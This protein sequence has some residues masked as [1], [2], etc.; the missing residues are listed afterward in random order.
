[1]TT[2]LKEKKKI[3]DF[4]YNLSETIKEE[5]WVSY[6]DV[7]SDS[8]SIISPKLSFSAHKKYIDSEF[9]F[10]FTP[11]KDIQGVFIEYFKTNFLKHHK[12]V[13]KLQ[14]LI[15]NIIKPEKK[16][17]VVEIKE[18][19]VKRL[20]PELESAIKDSLIQNIEIRSSLRV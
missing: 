17:A 15:K 12:E 20:A 5:R 14:E 1:M 19:M 13:K 3:F 7:E 16:K 8:L 18:Q 2:A 6:Y 10:Y 4:I 11:N 9:A